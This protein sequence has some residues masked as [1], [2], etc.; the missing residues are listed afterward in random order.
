M[1]VRIR[2]HLGPGFASR[3]SRNREIACL[4]AALLTPAAVAA[5]VLGIWR[6]ASDLNWTGDFVIEHGLFSHWQVWMVMAG[7]LETCAAIL[8]RYGRGGGE[9]TS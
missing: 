9:A 3:L 7:L 5:F 1:R 8:N 6:L 2:L 4:A